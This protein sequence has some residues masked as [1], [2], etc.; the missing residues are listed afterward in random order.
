MPCPSHSS[1]F[2][3][4]ESIGNKHA[5]VIIDFSFFITLILH[6]IAQCFIILFLIERRRLDVSKYASTPVFYNLSHTE[7]TIIIFRI[8][9][10][11]N[12]G[13]NFTGQKNVM[14]FYKYKSSSLTYGY[15]INTLGHV[16][17]G[18]RCGGDIL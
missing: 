15:V 5:T 17:G 11:T 8:F 16:G 12:I 4:F 7:N 13:K 2:Y 10:E 14:A 9:R 6:F 18:K 3:L 1:R